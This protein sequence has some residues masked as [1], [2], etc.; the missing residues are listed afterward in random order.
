M[1]LLRKM[2]KDVKDHYSITALHYIHAGHEGLQHICDVINGILADIRN[3]GLEELNT[4]HALIYYKGHSKDKTSDR[5]YRNISSCPFP[6]KLLDMYIRDL[7]G[8]LWKEQQAKTQY[9]GTGSS[10]ELASLLVT[11]VVQY[12]L[13][14]SKQPVY[15]LALDAQSAFDWCLRQVL[16]SE[17]YKAHMP[18][19]AVLLIDQRLANRCTV[20]E[21]EG[22][23]MGPAQDTTGFEQVG[24]NS[25]EYYKLYHNK[26]LT[27]AQKSLLGADIGSQEIAAVVKLMTSC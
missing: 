6:A 22:D 5:S 7:Y 26:Q 16:V 8:Y 1:E 3:A 19:A 20:Y 23:V 9:Q 24:V 10:H 27:T 11:E 14:V 2:K 18:P 17:L 25:S 4:A 15:L 12:S 21:W 13:H